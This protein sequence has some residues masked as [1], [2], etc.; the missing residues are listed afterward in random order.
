MS[1]AEQ[2]TDSL[3][4][5]KDGPVNFYLATDGA[6]VSLIDAGWPRSWKVVVGAL[7]SIGR[8][9]ADVS[10]ILI[11]HGHPDHIGAAERA[12]VE[13]GAKVHAS[14]AEIDLIKGEH[15]M[16]NPFKL[17]PSLIPQLWRPSALSFV[18]IATVKNFLFP[19]WVEEV[20]GFEPGTALDVPG[21]PVPHATPGHTEGH[22][23]FHFLDQGAVISGDALVTRDPISGKPGPCLTH[24][25]VNAAPADSRA[26]LS[27]LAALEGSIV[28]PGHGEPWTEGIKVAAEEAARRA[29]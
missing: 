24:D 7:E 25:A 5:V 9:P 1:A 19:K 16:S 14:N 22:V 6:E 26:S 20:E 13:T 10:A 12:R 28:L 29:S 27:T 15:R 3:H 23:S 8:K 11:T 18:G 21:R 2:V 17:V 4:R